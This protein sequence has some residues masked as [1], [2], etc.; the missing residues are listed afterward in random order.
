MILLPKLQPQQLRKLRLPDFVGLVILSRDK[1][2]TFLQ[3]VRSI[4]L[5]PEMDDYEKR[6]LRIF[7]QLNFLQFI[8]GILIP[9][10]G[11]YGAAKLPA[12]AWIIATVP[13]LV[14]MTVL[15]MNA[16]GQY[17]LARVFYFTFYPLLTCFIYISGLN[18]GVE[19]YFILYGILSV[20][21]L[22]DT[23]YMV[24]SIGF[25]MVSYFLLS[26]ILRD[27]H[28]QLRFVNGNAYLVNEALAIIYI[29]YGLYL[30]KTENNN[31]QFSIEKQKEEMSFQANLM[32][33]QAAE[34]T[35]L[36][37]LKNKLFSVISHDLKAPMY[38]MRNFFH[39]AREHKLPAREIRQ[40][41][42]DVINDLNYT[43]GLLENLLHW[44]K[45]QM[46]SDKVRPQELGMNGIIEEV[47]QVLR[48]QADAK[49]IVIERKTDLP[50]FAYADRDMITLVVR[51]ILSNALK[52]T[53]PGGRI[54]VG[55]NTYDCF[56]E[57]YIKDSGLGISPEEMKKIN[58]N[59]FY[60]TRGTASEAGTGLG[61]MLCKEFL[62]RNQ[63]RMMIESEPGAGSTFSF[64]L[65]LS[66]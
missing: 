8:T 49:K 46:Q 57:I 29:F 2:I 5:V 14:S 20:F 30:I 53:P 63:G 50:V 38:A 54:I 58:E 64:T 13:A 37:S 31:Y 47:I 52:Y 36:N 34:L 56:A 16:R 59:N 7:N 39:Q 19:L 3:R 45:S 61:L 35:E 27:Y 23:G 21:F 66:A 41:L 44:A 6:K 15:F 18:L 22:K 28:Y 25:S 24:F 9:L 32:K 43:T 1:S 60:T 26:V 51:N 33:L 42:P 10:F 4:G 17:M 55:T 48:L 62:L 12:N 40:M 11:L 65:P